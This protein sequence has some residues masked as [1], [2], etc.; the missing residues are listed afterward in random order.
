[1]G[2]RQAVDQ[3]VGD[4][5]DEDVVGLDQES[6]AAEA[7]NPGQ[8]DHGVLGAVDVADD[9]RGVGAGAELL[10]RRVGRR[11]ANLDSYAVG[12]GHPRGQP[13]RRASRVEGNDACPEADAQANRIV[14]LSGPEVDDDVGRCG[15]ELLGRFGDLEL[16]GA[17]ELG[18]ERRGR[19]VVSRSADR[20][21]GPGTDTGWSGERRRAIS[22][23]AP[24]RVAVA[25]TRQREGGVRCGD[26]GYG[27]HVL[28]PPAQL[29]RS[30]S[31]RAV[32][33]REGRH[34][35]PIPPMVRVE[36]NSR[37]GRLSDS[38]ASPLR[39]RCKTVDRAGE[40]RSTRSASSA[41]RDDP[42]VGAMA[43]TQ[44]RRVQRRRERQAAELT[45][46][47]RLARPRELRRRPAQ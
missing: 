3:S 19:D 32:V 18:Q 9:Q 17:G 13:A 44:G 8:V 20:R 28:D 35:W 36:R 14:A 1:M 12:R 38:R 16:V 47:A 6:C 15:D 33:G 37:R 24:D 25:R 45:G 7:R 42:R 23:S 2:G 21:R 29:P 41:R 46:D 40:A 26:A 34:C 22:R 30:M 4:P 27:G 31:G 11:A 39:P 43:S 5:C 10:D